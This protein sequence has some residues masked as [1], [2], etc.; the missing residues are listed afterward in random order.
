MTTRTT[1]FT[2]LAVAALLF[3]LSRVGKHEHRCITVADAMQV[4]GNCRRN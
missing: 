3:V 1:I 2:I 4:A